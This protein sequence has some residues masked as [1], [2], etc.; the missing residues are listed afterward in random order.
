MVA[1]RGLDKG[2]LGP[3]AMR[4]SCESSLRLQALF[5]VL[6]EPIQEF[7]ENGP[8]RGNRSFNG[9]RSL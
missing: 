7:C 1:A 8:L 4:L 2:F 6:L 3:Q 9:Y 5:L